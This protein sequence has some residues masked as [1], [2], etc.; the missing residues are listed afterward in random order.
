MFFNGFGRSSL[1]MY[2]LLLILFMLKGE[3]VDRDLTYEGLVGSDVMNTKLRDFWSGELAA[4]WVGWG[5]VG[6]LVSI[7]FHLYLLKSNFNQ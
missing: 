7:L 6:W 2:N 4:G 3:H 1:L 5:G